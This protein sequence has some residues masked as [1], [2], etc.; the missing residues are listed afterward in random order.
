MKAT[1]THLNQGIRE[2]DILTTK[3]ITWNAVMGND[4]NFYYK[5]D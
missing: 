1:M 3:I 4:D 5:V 2:D